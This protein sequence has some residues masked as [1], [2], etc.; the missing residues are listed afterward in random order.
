MAGIEPTSID[1]KS[2]MLPLHHILIIIKDL[3]K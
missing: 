2:T 1:P 3:H